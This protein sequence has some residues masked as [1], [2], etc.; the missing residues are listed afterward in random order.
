MDWSH[1]AAVCRFGAE[2]WWAASPGAGQQSGAS[3]E[4]AATAEPS[5]K[6]VGIGA[7]LQSGYPN[8]KRLFPGSPAESS[9]QLHPGDWVVAV[10][11]G[12]HAF[13]DT[14]NLSLQELVQPFVANPARR[15]GFKSCRPMR[16]RVRRRKPSP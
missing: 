11:Q 12:D 14:H 2:G 16:R 13:V 5:Y 4:S 15:S 9:G 7:E 8:I 6:L 3:K 1:A 10:A